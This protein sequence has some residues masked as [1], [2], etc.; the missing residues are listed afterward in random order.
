MPAGVGKRGEQ[1]MTT[2]KPGST[3]LERHEIKGTCPS[4]SDVALIALGE[5]VELIDFAYAAG[6]PTL[7]K[8]LERAK[9]QAERDLG[10]HPSP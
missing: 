4:P 5:L 8:S 9:E 3:W 2:A 6:H 7:A 10:L 1:M